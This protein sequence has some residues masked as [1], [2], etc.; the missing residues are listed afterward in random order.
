MN[1]KETIVF[2]AETFRDKMNSLDIIKQEVEFLCASFDKNIREDMT[3]LLDEFL[4]HIS[5]ART[6][7]SG[8]AATAIQNWESYD[9]DKE[10]SL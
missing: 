3:E 2:L 7:L 6:S 10:A 5:D 9:K 1:N 8:L 4:L